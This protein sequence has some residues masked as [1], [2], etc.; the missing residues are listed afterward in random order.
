MATQYVIDFVK[1]IEKEVLD[2][3][4]C[5]DEAKEFVYEAVSLKI[6][7]VT[8]EVSSYPIDTE[9]KT[10]LRSVLRKLRA[11]AQKALSKSPSE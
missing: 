4:N 9:V 3:M 6:E 10:T 11:A 2:S 7:A 1:E 8:A 5:S